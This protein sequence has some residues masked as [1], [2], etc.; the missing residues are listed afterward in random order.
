MKRKPFL[1]RQRGAT[2]MEVLVTMVIVAFG[3]LG[4][5][6]FQ[7][8]AQVG[9][10]ESYQRAQAIILLDDMVSRLT[11]N[12]ANA[13]SYLSASVGTGDTQ[14]ADCTTLV[15]GAQRDLC[16]W[17]QSLKGAAEKS[18]TGTQ[19]GAMIGARGC[20]IQVQAPN[21][22]I[23]VCQPA[24]Y[25]VSVAWQGLHETRAPTLTCGL[26]QYGNEKYRR[27]ISARVTVGLTTCT[28]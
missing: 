10:V 3:L 8:K 5:A 24:I 20:V 11:G 25:E 9:A 22:L 2:M 28:T 1:P 17:S 18:E 13:A 12:S 26:N 6:A 27:V 19:V 15:Q 4:V 14:P 16:E 7:A 21:P 23:G